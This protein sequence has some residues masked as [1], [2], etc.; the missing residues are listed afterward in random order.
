MKN[1][2]LYRIGGLRKPAFRFV[3]Y[4]CFIYR[5]M[6]CLLCI[7]IYLHSA[8]QPTK[9]QQDVFTVNAM[10][11]RGINIPSIE[12]MQASHYKVIK[13]AGFNNVRIPIHPFN[14]TMG[15]SAFT[16]KPEY[17][18]LVDTA[19]Y[20]ALDNQLIPIIDFH[21]HNAMQKDPLGTRPMFLA[22][23]KQLAEHYKNFPSQVLFEIANEPNMK[24]DLWNDLHSSAYAIIRKSN[25]TR[26]LL[27]GPIYGNQIKYLKDLK[28]PEQDR[29]IIVTIHYY[30]PIQFTHQGAPWSEKNKNLS[31]IE[32]PGAYGNEDSVRKDFQLAQDWSKTYGRPL[33]LGEFG[34]YNKAGM[35]SRIQWT[36]FVAREAEKYKW[37]WS[38][39]EFNQGFGI[40]NLNTGEWKVG[41]YKA[42]IPSKE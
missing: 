39:W 16:L 22:L 28:L 1:S 10:L 20:R 23:W 32:W 8:G 37:S 36:A 14:Q 30:M 31:G 9:K 4:T 35:E 21:E 18:K 41:L 11:G 24:P 13:Q 26:V 15:D 29:N 40:Y 34:V 33:H 2:Q 25:P 6:L 42:L 17:V 38:Y 12:T 27:I 5:Y 7:F 19:V 3:Q